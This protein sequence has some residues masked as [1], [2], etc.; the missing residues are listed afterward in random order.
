MPRRLSQ[1][2]KQRHLPGQIRIVQIAL[3]IQLGILPDEVV[4]FFCWVFL[5]RPVATQR[6]LMLFLEREA[7]NLRELVTAMR[8]SR[9]PSDNLGSG[10]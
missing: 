10:C 5:G 1:P 8:V 9:L 2:G 6:L 4:S 7:P 3:L